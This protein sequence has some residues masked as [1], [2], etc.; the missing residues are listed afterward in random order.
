MPGQASA[1]RNPMM[2]CKEQQFHWVSKSLSKM[3]IR[4]YNEINLVYH[5]SPGYE[6]LKEGIYLTDIMTENYFWFIP[7]SVYIAGSMG[8]EPVIRTCNHHGAVP[9]LHL[10]LTSS[11][12][13]LSQNSTKSVMHMGTQWNHDLRR[14]GSQPGPKASRHSRIS[15]KCLECVCV[16]VK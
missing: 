1:G 10:L 4:G 13:Q 7:P 12:I 6:G 15:S 8:C 11:F 16:V 9:P 14:V 5:A 3:E 2:H